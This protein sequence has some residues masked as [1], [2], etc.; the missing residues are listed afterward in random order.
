[1]DSICT[2]P[3]GKILGDG[4]KRREFIVKGLAT[5]KD[6]WGRIG[7]HMDRMISGGLGHRACGTMVLSNAQEKHEVGK[8][9][10]RL[11]PDKRVRWG[12]GNPYLESTEEKKGSEQN[13]TNH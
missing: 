6:E 4:G 13:Q 5:Q 8:T 7:T 2:S 3:L 9:T 12:D 1:M 10:G 11:G